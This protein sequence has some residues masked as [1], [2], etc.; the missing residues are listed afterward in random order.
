M[1]HLYYFDIILHAWHCNNKTIYIIYFI[2]PWGQLL[3]YR[4][5]GFKYRTRKRYLWLQRRNPVLLFSHLFKMLYQTYC[6]VFNSLL[7]SQEIGQD[8]SKIVYIFRFDY[9][10]ANRP[11][12]VC[13]GAIWTLYLKWMHS[14]LIAFQDIVSNCVCV[15]L[16]K[17]Q[18]NCAIGMQPVINM[19]YYKYRPNRF[20]AE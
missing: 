13:N 16:K 2:C 20:T 15:K 5:H 14:F 18:N 3:C 4:S 6:N 12:S 1:G 11:F 8:L 7:W 9:F 17:H 10:I 19:I